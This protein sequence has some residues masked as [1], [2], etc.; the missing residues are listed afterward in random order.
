MDSLYLLPAHRV[1]VFHHMVKIACEHIRFDVDPPIGG[2]ASK[3]GMLE[4]DGNDREP[5]TITQDFVYGKAHSIHGDTSF[6]YHESH[7][8]SWY[9]DKKICGVFSPLYSFYHAYAVDMALND[10][11][12]EAVT[13]FHG[14]LYMD[15]SFIVL[16]SHHFSRFISKLH[17]EALFKYVRHT[18]TGSIYGYGVADV[19]TIFGLESQYFPIE[20]YNF[21][22]LFYKSREQEHP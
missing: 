5:K 2:V 15:S 4:S 18:Q 22:Y 1:F 20:I 17:F 16:Q 13:R 19:G 8:L 3:E 9:P 11:A 7:I 12:L 14:G 6:G 21:G 10:M